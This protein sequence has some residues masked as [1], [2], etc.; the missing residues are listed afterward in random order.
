LYFY[1]TG[2][3]C[4]LLNLSDQYQLSTH[5]LRGEIFE[6]MII[7]EFIKNSLAEGKEPE[8]YFWRDS[9]Q[10]EIDLLYELNGKINAIEIKSAATLNNRFLGN[11]KHFQSVS[12]IS[13]Q[14][15]F[16][17][18]GG[19]LDYYTSDGS[20]ISWKNLADSEKFETISYQ[21]KVLP[22]NYFC[23]RQITYL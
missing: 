5:Y 4:A 3:I 15:L 12:Q 2:L 22:L 20:F 13:K 9:N 16:V 19:D 18:Y 23:I 1:D 7:N 17:V 21:L 11:L 8:L 14:N 6:N 10:N